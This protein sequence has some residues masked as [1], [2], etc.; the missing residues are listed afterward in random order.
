MSP[1]RQ[2]GLSY[3]ARHAGEF[4]LNRSDLLNPN[5]TSQYTDADSGTTYIYARQTVAGLDVAWSD[6]SIAVAADGHVISIGGGY[7]P[8]LA[9][10]LAGTSIVPRTSPAD[11]VRYAAIELGLPTDHVPI[12]STVPTGTD[13]QSMVSAP[14]ISL[15][16]IPTRLQ[17]VPTAD[18]SAVL[19]WQMILRTPDGNHWYDLSVGDSSHSII[20]VTDWIDDASFNVVPLPNESPQ[21]GGFAVLNNPED[22]T[23]S[24]FGWHDTNGAAGAEFTDTRGNNVD[25]HLDR[26]NDNV[27]DPSPPRT[28]GGATLDFSSFTLDPAQ[29]P[30]LLQ[31]QNVAMVN[32]FYMNNIIH[33]IHY[34]YGFTEAAGNFQVNNYA[35]GG[36]ANDAVQADAQDG[37]GTNNANFATPV[38]GSAPRM[39][40]Y[41]FTTATPNRDGDLDNGIII[42]EYGHGVSNRLTGGPGNSGALSATQSGGMGEGW[43]DWYALMLMQRPTDAMNDA[44]PIGTYAL[45]Q[46]QTGA[47]IRRKPYSFD[48][49]VDPLDF[50]AYGTTGTTS[51][52]VTRSTE[53]HNSGEL[54]ASALWDINW[55]LINKY[56]YDSNLATGYTPGPLPGG[57][58]NKLALKLIMDAMKLQPALPS[59]IQARDAI[60]AAD[61]ALNGGADLLELW[62]AFARRGLGANASTA[63]SNATTVTVD[64]TIPPAV[65]GLLVNSSVPAN[66]SVVL[67][68]PGTYVL[69][70]SGILDGATLDASDL[71][72]NGKPATGYSYT[73]GTKTV[74]FTFAIDPVTAE[75]LQSISVAAGAFNQLSDGKPVFA[76]NASFRYDVLQM[77]V[78]STSPVV[79]ATVLVPLTTIDV[80]LNEPVDPASVIASDLGVSQGSVSSVAFL[81]S[82]QTIRFTLTGATT[83]GAFNATIAAGAIADVNGNVNLAFAGSYQLDVG[84]RAFPL[85][86]TAI[87]PLGSAVYRG[88][89]T[90]VVSS[91]ADTDDFTLPLNAGQVLSLVITSS[92]A[93]RARVIVLSPTLVT[94]AD[95]SASVAGAAMD[96]PPIAIAA[97]GTYTIRMLSVAATSGNYAVQAN[98]NAAT[99]TESIAGGGGNNK[100]I[101][102]QSLTPATVTTTTALGSATRATVLGVADGVSNYTAA[103][104]TYAFEEIGGTGA[105]IL[106][107]LDDDFAA[108]PNPSPSTF[109]VRT[110]TRC[111]PRRTAS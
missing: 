107:S 37:G 70:T 25:S 2:L 75:G 67:T 44:V 64:Y 85:P 7:V 61:M 88:S 59:F 51:Y 91:G 77:A 13:Q 110:I 47:G 11:A 65:L 27:A 93:L 35:K 106:A 97:T 22:L 73:A 36:L 104:V 101:T 20:A 19:A 83:E 109:T 92:A 105:T 23:A 30:T 18:G 8:N 53:V 1:P 32:L 84:T 68:H 45:N 52:G 49:T 5:I 3:L 54:W 33:D 79:G 56:G 80:N 17:W 6:M 63:N 34:K 43:S 89:A 31:N 60:L 28:S 86:L 12:I 62:T 66:N 103:A 55:L 16:D 72:V 41:L 100:S 29:A 48:L 90:G 4:N 95:V 9:G 39:Q 46:A 111:S 26:N 38:D 82:N 76:Y 21:D 40:M 15:D 96:V 87:N 71:V 99:E 108:I 10:Q 94:L 57:A 14:A 78:V 24:P 81:N 98:L 58:G 50:D 102:A 42:H 74:S 69:N